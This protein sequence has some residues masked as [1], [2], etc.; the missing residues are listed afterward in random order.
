MDQKNFFTES[1]IYWAPASNPRDLYDQLSRFKFREIRRQ[2]IQWVADLQLKIAC[3]YDTPLICRVVEHIGSGQFGT[4]SKGVWQ[5]PE[6]AVD[7][8]VKVLHPGSQEEDRMKFLQEAAIM[9][10]FKNP[11]VIMLHGVVTVGEPVRGSHLYY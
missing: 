3:F 6:G 1:E 9:G 5:S 7:V 4:V 10:Q 11:N 8:A 2:H